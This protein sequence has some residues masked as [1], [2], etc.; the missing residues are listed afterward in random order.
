VAESIAREL[1]L[2]HP[3]ERVWAALTDS[4]MLAQWL[5]P[6]DFAP[7]LGHRF[8]FRT[9]PLPQFDF[10][11]IT[12]CQVVEL[13]P[14]HRLSYSWRGGDL[15]TLVTFELEPIG[16]G[17]RLLF[18]HSGFDLDRPSNRSA[19]DVLGGGWVGILQKLS[20]LIKSAGGDA[21]LVPNPPTAA[22]TST[23]EQA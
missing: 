17:T 4:A 20:D 18:V 15:D 2:P 1:I 8:T 13:E 22:T 3:P 19:F 7:Q 11:G 16:V 9:Q 21:S 6:N 14:P 10:D 23:Q 12:Y 5:M